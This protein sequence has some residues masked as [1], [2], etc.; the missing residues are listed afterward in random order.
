MDDKLIMIVLVFF[1]LKMLNKKS[2]GC[3][4]NFASP[5]TYDFYNTPSYRTKVDCSDTPITFKKFI[6][7]E[8]IK[9]KPIHKAQKETQMLYEKYRNKYAET[10]PDSE[11]Y[12]KFSATI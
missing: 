6:N 5:S 1:V 2:C 8:G 4:E 10:C 12:A 7:N 3:N 9:W 11:Y